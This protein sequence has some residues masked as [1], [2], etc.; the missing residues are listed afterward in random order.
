MKDWAELVT[1]WEAEWGN[2][3]PP[4]TM[5]DLIEQNA[6][7]TW[8]TPA[9]RDAYERWAPLA[10]RHLVDTI[11]DEIGVDLTE[12]TPEQRHPISRTD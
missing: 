5:Q 2:L 9:H 11:R 1:G 8:A 3:N 6:N 12:D 7:G 4:A 10:G